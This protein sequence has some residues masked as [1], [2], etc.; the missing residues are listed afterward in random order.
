[1]RIILTACAVALVHASGGASAQTPPKSA[2]SATAS[3]TKYSISTTPL[4]VLLADPAAKAVVEKAVPKLVG[5]AEVAD[6]AGGMTLKE[7]QEAMKAYAPD[8][9]TDAILT[10]I[11]TDLAKI[12][13][14]N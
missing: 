7:I 6:R 11:D 14:K 9:L 2:P 4:N 8:M 12:P 10:Q 5:N 3:A 13:V 1:M